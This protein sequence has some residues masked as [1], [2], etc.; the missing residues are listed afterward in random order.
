MTSTLC[1]TFLF[2]AIFSVLC[3]AHDTRLSKAFLI[4]SKHADEHLC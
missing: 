3:T 1:R 4:T 2:S